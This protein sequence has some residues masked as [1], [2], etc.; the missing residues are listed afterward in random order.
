MKTHMPK[1]HYVKKHNLLLPTKTHTC[2]K[3][4]ASYP[5]PTH[6]EKWGLDLRLTHTANKVC[7]YDTLLVSFQLFVIHNNSSSFCFSLPA[8]LRTMKSWMGA[9]EQGYTQRAVESWTGPA[10]AVESWMGVCE[11]GY[12]QRAVESWTG[13]VNLQWS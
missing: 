13:P 3:H 8:I 10:Q 9:Y 6:V 1:N 5:G 4:L 12:V 7:I 2:N 11:Q